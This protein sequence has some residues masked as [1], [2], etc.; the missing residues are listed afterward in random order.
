MDVCFSKAMGIEIDEMVKN[1][2]IFEKLRNFRAGI[3]SIISCLKRGYG[4]DRI[5]WKGVQGF[6][7]YV[8]I[9]VFFLEENHK[10]ESNEH[11]VS[12]NDFGRAGG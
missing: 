10:L 5:T 12:W 9:T 1:R 8:H 7:S 2:W 4:L 6:G 3:E 11:Q